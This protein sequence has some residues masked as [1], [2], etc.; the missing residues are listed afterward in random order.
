MDRK[1]RGMLALTAAA[2]L[3]GPDAAA[4]GRATPFPLVELRQYRTR[5]DKRD[6]LI[7]LFEREFVETQEAVGLKIVGTFREPSQPDRFVWLRGF[8]DMD[9]RGK[10]L[11]AFYFG[12]VWQAHRGA[13]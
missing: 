6:T 3:D 7:E 2:A 9:A 8:A 10:G 5:P 11:N 4:K 13:T 1:R 12:P